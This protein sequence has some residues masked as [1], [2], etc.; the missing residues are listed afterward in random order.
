MQFAINW[1]E[2]QRKITISISISISSEWLRRS[3]TLH[4]SLAEKCAIVVNA[5]KTPNKLKLFWTKKRELLK[6]NESI[7][8]IDTNVQVKI[9]LPICITRNE[10]KAALI[11][12]KTAAIGYVTPMC[13]GA[14]NSNNG[15]SFFPFLMSR[16]FVYIWKYMP[17][18]TMRVRTESR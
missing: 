1:H 13:Y 2:E 9:G 7:K 12:L 4:T 14:S 18:L 16:S 6:R 17:G 11:T 5:T 10:F 3:F 15:N 8:N